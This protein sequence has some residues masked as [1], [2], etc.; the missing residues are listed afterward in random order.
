MPWYMTG[1]ELKAGHI[2]RSA[3]FKRVLG[4]RETDCFAHHG[5]T[6]VGPGIADALAADGVAGKS[7]VFPVGQQ[8]RNGN[9]MIKMAVCQE[10]SF[11]RL[12]AGFQAALNGITVTAGIDNDTGL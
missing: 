2:Q 12:T 6:Q 10:Y 1:I 5:R 4:R 11:Q 3:I 7:C 8:I 9:G